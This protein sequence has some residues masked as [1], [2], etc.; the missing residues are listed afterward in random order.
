MGR[1]HLRPRVRHGVPR[2]QR[3]SR[4]RH[5]LRDP[6]L[7]VP[8]PGVEIRMKKVHLVVAG[9]LLLVTGVLANLAP[10]AVVPDRDETW[11]AER[12][13][14]GFDGYTFRSSLDNPNLSYR[15]T[16]ITYETLKP[17]GI[18]S[19]IYEKEGKAFDTVVIA[20]QNSDSFH[21]PRVCFQSQGSTLE[22]Q[23]EVAIDTKTRG[24]VPSTFIETNYN[25]QKRIA[26]YMYK[27]PKGFRAAPGQ[28]MMDMFLGEIKTAQI[29]EGVFYRFIALNPQTTQD[30]L[31][32]YMGQFV[33]AVSEKSDRYF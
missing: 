4:P 12:I 31:A 20:S 32:K 27:G 6:S 17:Y 18:V 29:Q 5:L 21:D 9:T 16:P 26:A 1:Q 7:G 14:A 28:L 30:D 3:L 25:G 15:M 33:D 10:R 8:S 19:R 24:K 23:R 2:L 11:M 22:G 13:P